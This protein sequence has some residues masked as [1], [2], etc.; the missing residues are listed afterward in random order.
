M[1]DATLM[2]FLNSDFHSCPPTD[3]RFTFNEQDGVIKEVK[4]HKMILA[5]VSDVFYREFYGSLPAESD[6]EIKDSRH[7]IFLT[8][9][10]FIYNKKPNYKD[11]D[12]EF[13]SSLYYLADKYNIA[14]LRNRIIAS[15][16]E[17]DVTK[18]NVLDVA[19]LAEENILH[20]PLSEA[21]YD[22]SASFVMKTEGVEHEMFADENE[23]QAVVVFKIMNRVK[24]VKSGK[25]QM[26][27]TFCRCL[28]VPCKNGEKVTSQ[29][30]VKGGRLLMLTELDTGS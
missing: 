1:A 13:L 30:F 20:Q 28:Q 26:K 14:E 6:I 16:P 7:G 18:D 4:A 15:I 10:E 21:L 27:S 3:I 29:N 23:K 17:H 2:K 9:I 24:K 22:A 5:S 11:A 12:L 25:V 8:M 19:L